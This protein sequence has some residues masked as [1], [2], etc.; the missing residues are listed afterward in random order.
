MKK[1]AKYLIC[2]LSVFVFSF[3]FSPIL[4]SDSDQPIKTV[5]YQNH[6]SQ[7]EIDQLLVDQTEAYLKEIIPDYEANTKGR[8]RP[9]YETVYGTTKR[10][11]I[12]GYAGNQLPGGYK[13]PTGGGFYYSFS[14]GPTAS[15]SV[16]F[17]AP[18]G[19]FG[20]STT[21]GNKAASGV[22]VNVPNKT[23]Y[24][25]L[26]STQEYNVRPFIVYYID[27]N[28]KKGV[29]HK[30]FSSVQQSNVAWAKAV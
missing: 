6:L 19:S 13:F 12:G 11:N 16:S 23:Q 26:W 21:L 10:V 17:P 28:G 5:I 2:V 25:K 22:T 7:A 3:S 15:V 8:A 27:S 30:N 1:I 24:F 29:Y 4:A 18:F 9:Y 14:G 20:L